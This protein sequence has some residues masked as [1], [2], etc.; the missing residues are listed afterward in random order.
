MMNHHGGNHPGGNHAHIQVRGCAERSP[1]VKLPGRVAHEG[2]CSIA[3]SIHH[4]VLVGWRRLGVEALHDRLDEIPH[5][6]RRTGQPMGSLP[7]LGSAQNVSL[8]G[9]LPARV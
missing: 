8:L 3:V 6:T 1:S 2:R 4:K 7:R 5:L 9:S